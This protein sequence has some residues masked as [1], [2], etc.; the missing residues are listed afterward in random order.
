M[1]LAVFLPNWVG[2]AVMAT[3]ALRALRAGFPHARIVGVM[4]P[5][6]A[7]VL[8]GTNWLD[9]QVLFDPRSAERDRRTWAVTRRLR[10]LRPETVVLLTNSFR[11]GLM[12]WLSGAT[13]RAGYSM[14]G[15]HWL[16]TDRLEPPRRDGKLVPSPVIDA[17]LRLAGHLGCAPASRRI[18]LATLPADEA[19]ADAVWR[20]FHLPVGQQVVLLNCSGAYGEAKL[21]PPAHFAELARRL[22]AERG[23]SV[24]V[25]CGPQERGLARQIASEAGHPRVCSLAD[26]PSSIGLSKACVRRAALLIT[27]DSGPRHFAAAFSI[28]VVTLFGP[29]HPAWSENYHPLD[30]HLQR[31]VPCGPCQ[32]RRCPL[33]H[34]RCMRELSVDEVFHAAWALLERQACAGGGLAGVQGGQAA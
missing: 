33:G 27:T 28:P 10:A 23:R 12:A 6:V 34:H 15:R 14:H 9:A 5:V 18:E 32:Q 26:F 7:E 2:D 13:R 30:V 29:T 19:A 1:T 4:R 11:T 25:L 8:A 22:A 16:L 20:H 31:Q 21:W 17:Y 24:L 3:P